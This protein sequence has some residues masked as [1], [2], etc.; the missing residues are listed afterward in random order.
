MFCSSLWVIVPNRR[1]GKFPVFEI[2]LNAHLV[3]EELIAHA[4]GI[5]SF[6]NRF[7]F[8][9]GSIHLIM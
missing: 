1:N 7:V 5:V 8:Q 4:W 6:K 3:Y 2:P 9:N